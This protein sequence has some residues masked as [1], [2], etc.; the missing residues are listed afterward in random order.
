[1]LA[2]WI[3]PEFDPAK[4]A[5]YYLRVLENPT[6]HWTTYDAVRFGVDLPG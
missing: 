5:F 4:R 6:R 2:Y 1:M 3:E